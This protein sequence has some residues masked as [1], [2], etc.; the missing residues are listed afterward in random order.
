MR[1]DEFLQR[2]LDVVEIDVGDETVDTG[3]DASRLLPMNVAFRGNKIGEYP[4]IRKP[5][6]VGGV[7]SIAADA[8]EVVALEIEF[9][10]LA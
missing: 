8:L 7:G 9:L 2:G 1:D 6:R 3:I 5:P 4:Q 10:R